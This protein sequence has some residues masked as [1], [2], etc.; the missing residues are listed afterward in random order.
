LIEIRSAEGGDD[1][2]LLVKKLFQIYLKYSKIK[3]FTVEVSYICESKIGWSKVEFLVKGIDAYQNFLPEAGGHRW[4]RVPETEKRG[5]RQTSTVTVAVLPM[6]ESAECVIDKKDLEW[7]TFCAPK[8]GGQ[9]SNKVETAVRLTHRS[10]GLSVVCCDEKSQR[11]NKDR[12]L[13][14]LRARLYAKNL[15]ESAEKE[16]S[17]RREQIGSGQRGDKIRTL[18]YK[19]DIVIDHNSGKK[20]RLSEVLSG[21]LDILR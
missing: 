2:K 3:N 11:R 10:S 12:A 19:D 7:Q 20:V 15:K 14:V 4:Q 13:E 18:R 17:A 6:V 1:S 8:P 21:N 16:N 9:H 5:R